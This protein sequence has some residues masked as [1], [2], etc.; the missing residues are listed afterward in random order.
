MANLLY[1]VGGT[2]NLFGRVI[3]AQVTSSP[4]MD[5]NFPI[6]G[7][8][9]GEPGTVAKYGSAAAN[10]TITV[11][12]DLLGATGAFEAAFVG[13]APVGF[14][15]TSTLSGVNTR[16]TVAGEF[17]SGGA[18]KCAS[19]ATA[20]AMAQA[21]GLIRVRPGEQFRL[22]GRVRGDGLGGGNSARCYL[23]NPV[24]GQWYDGIGNAWVTVQTTLFQ[25]NAAAYTGANEVDE[26]IT[27]ESYQA[28][29]GADYVDLQLQLGTV[30]L[31]NRTAFYDE[32]YTWPITN[33]A[34]LLGIQD[35]G[36]RQ[37]ATPSRAWEWYA[38]SQSSFATQSSIALN[39][40]A[41]G[42]G[43]GIPNGYAKVADNN[44]RFN[45]FNFPGTPTT[46]PSFGEA[47][48]GYATAA[49]KQQN[50]AYSTTVAKR[51]L[52]N[53]TRGGTTRVYPF[54]TYPERTVALAFRHS[55]RADMEEL[56]HEWF[57]RSGGGQVPMV[58]V[59]DDSG[60]GL[61]QAVFHGRMPESVAITR[62]LSSV[63][64]W[65]AVVLTESPLP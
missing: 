26:T 3:A 38:D 61:D 32:W 35:L 42:P 60:T 63:W 8:G 54:A 20:L 1:L 6:S 50:I 30:N 46:P 14:T 48:F 47:I 11:D 2:L 5:A 59:L 52:R 29:G 41:T 53:V 7:L 18:L 4:A 43:K 16:T 17:V 27:V 36:P 65:E 39:V 13:G 37:A 21:Q 25:T 55:A 10:S 22:V 12:G 56:L 15:N 62:S 23:K 45:R 44:L 19:G 28:C 58:L 33:F 34:A 64:D 49:L 51:Q 40:E 31:A 9:D 57:L 24:T